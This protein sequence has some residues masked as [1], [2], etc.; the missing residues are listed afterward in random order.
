MALNIPALPPLANFACTLT[1]ALRAVTFILL[2]HVFRY[3]FMTWAGHF[4]LQARSDEQTLCV[5]FSCHSLI[6]GAG[7]L[8]HRFE[9]LKVFSAFCMHSL[10]VHL[11][12][13][14]TSWF[15]DCFAS[16][17]NAVLQEIFLCVLRVHVC[18]AMPRDMA[19]PSGMDSLWQ[20]ARN[21]G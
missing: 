11:K 8:L 2:T 12:D 9:E 15:Y 1:I 7:E 19:T 16:A 5:N 10:A 13:S 3:D 20:E 21:E 17:H 6:T 18:P 14:R 4:L